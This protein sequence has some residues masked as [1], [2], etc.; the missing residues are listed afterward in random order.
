MSNGSPRV[1]VVVLVVVVVVVVDVEEVVDTMQG[2][3]SGTGCPV[4]L[5]R[6]TRA[7]VAATGS[8]PPGAQMHSGSQVWAPT[9]V[10]KMKRQS[11]A[12]GDAPPVTGWEQ[13]PWSADAETTASR[14][15][16]AAG[17][18]ARTEN[19]CRIFTESPS[20]HW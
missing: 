12:A 13:S 19:R 5:A 15:N 6:H 16:A 10:C 2:Q 14:Q 18:A 11:V 8:D 1:V 9:A 3:S 4:A 17:P 7:S 20:V